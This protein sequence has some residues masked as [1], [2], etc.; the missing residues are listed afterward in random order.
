MLLLEQMNVFTRNV[1]ESRKKQCSEF[2]DVKTDT[3]TDS[4]CLHIYS[5]IYL[6]AVIF[7]HSS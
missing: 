4:V 1:S 5:I 3:Q 2:K 7:L 6:Y